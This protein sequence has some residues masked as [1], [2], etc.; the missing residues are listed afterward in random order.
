M[1]K[2]LVTGGTGFLGRA[3]IKMLL[4][5]NVSVNVKLLCEA[6]GTGKGVSVKLR[7]TPYVVPALVVT[8]AL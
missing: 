6:I 5:E 7:S 3:I 1:K 8:N 2:V 4:A